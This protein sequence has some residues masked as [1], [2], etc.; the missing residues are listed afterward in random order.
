MNADR[1]NI[2]N[3]A[4]GDDVIFGIT[5]NFKFKLLPAADALLNKNLTN[6]AC[7]KST[8]ADNL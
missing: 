7:L 1:I 6:K 5:D 4:D 2:L 8:F 3:K